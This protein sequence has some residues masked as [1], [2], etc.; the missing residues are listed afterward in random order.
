MALG[1]VKRL[2]TVVCNPDKKQ[3]AITDQTSGR[4]CP[5]R[6]ENDLEAVVPQVR[7]CQCR[8]SQTWKP[9]IWLACPENVWGSRRQDVTGA[10]RCNGHSRDGY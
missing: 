7:D 5:E 8:R 2:R 10:L 3:D 1:R 9:M 4:K 6:S